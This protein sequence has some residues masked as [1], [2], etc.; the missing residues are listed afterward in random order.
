MNQMNP[1]NTLKRLESQHTDVIFRFFV[2]VVLVL[3]SVH[4]FFGGF[5][6]AVAQVGFGGQIE[7]VQYCT[8]SLNILLTIGPPVAGEFLY[9]PGGSV[10]FPYGQVYRT[11]PWTLGTYAPGGVCAIYIGTGCS[12]LPTNG[13]MS[14]VGTSI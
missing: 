2:G 3:L 12:T 4:L 10:L 1:I 8:C 13:T 5:S 11:G 6:S 9:Q 7:Y 14:V